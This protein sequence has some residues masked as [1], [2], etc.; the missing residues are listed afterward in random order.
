MMRLIDT[1]VLVCA[2]APRV[3]ALMMANCAIL[4]AR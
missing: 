1:N 3:D 4:I 2:P